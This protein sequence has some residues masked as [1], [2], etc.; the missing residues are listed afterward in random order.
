MKEVHH[1]SY[2]SASN[3]HGET[4]SSPKVSFKE[5]L[6]GEMPG[7]YAQTFDFSEHMDTD[8][9]SDDE[10][11]EIREGFAAIRLSKETKQRIRAPWAKALIIKV[12]GRTVGFSYLHSRIMGL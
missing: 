1:A 2:G 3:L 8:S 5:K 7:V 6:V 4:K 11:S 10:S 9:D 12:F